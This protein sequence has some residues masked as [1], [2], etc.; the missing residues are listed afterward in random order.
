[1]SSSDYTLMACFIA[2]VQTLESRIKSETNE[3]NKETLITV[4]KYLEDRIAF[5]KK[6]IE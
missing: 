6:G 4:K 3:T 1:M 2:E 5:F